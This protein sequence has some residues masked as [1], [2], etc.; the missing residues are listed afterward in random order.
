MEI[1][2]SRFSALGIED[3]DFYCVVHILSSKLAMRS[4]SYFERVSSIM[5]L[6]GAPI[7]DN[8]YMYVCMYLCVYV[9]VCAQCLCPSNYGCCNREVSE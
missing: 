7:H 5:T 9:C 1:V 2:E 6:A 4:F 3:G 8:M